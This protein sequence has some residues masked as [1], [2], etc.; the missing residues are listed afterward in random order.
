MTGVVGAAV[1]ALI[2]TLL[3]AALTAT[4]AIYTSS[5]TR[6]HELDVERRRFERDEQKHRRERREELYTRFVQAG[7]DV[8]AGLGQHSDPKRNAPSTVQIADMIE[9]RRKLAREVQLFASADV[10]KRIEDLVESWKR[11]LSQNDADRPETQEEIT[12]RYDVL[13]NAARL[14][15][16]PQT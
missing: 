6:R 8:E 1:L 5:A 11:W 9:D 14:E 15:L 2:G 13:V 16:T 4:V 12:N 10:S 7:H 3:G